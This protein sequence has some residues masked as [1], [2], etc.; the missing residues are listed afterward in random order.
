[1]NKTN[2][3]KKKE[4]FDPKTLKPFDKVII[5]I[6]DFKWKIDFFSHNSDNECHPY[7]CVSN[8]CQYCIHYND[9]TKHLV[10]TTD[11]APEFY[12]NWEE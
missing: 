4:R 3:N 2:I 9:E 8:S 12:K 5:R 1:M 6:F 10:G 11:E 7:R